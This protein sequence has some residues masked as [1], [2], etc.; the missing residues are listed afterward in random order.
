MSYFEADV[1]CFYENY[2][3]GLSNDETNMLVGTTVLS[4]DIRKHFVI[5]LLLF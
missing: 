1:L 3:I 4:E 5:G 2:L